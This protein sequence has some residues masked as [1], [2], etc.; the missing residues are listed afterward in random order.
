[1]S[2][3]TPLTEEERNAAFD[4]IFQAQRHAIRGDPMPHTLAAQFH[5]LWMQ[6]YVMIYDDR[7][8]DLRTD[9]PSLHWH[10]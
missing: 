1:M 8:K 3:H 7:L 6:G 4:V 5:S 10:K 2:N 9:H